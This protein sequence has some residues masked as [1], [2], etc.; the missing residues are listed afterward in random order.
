MKSVFIFG[1]GASRHAGGPLMSDFFDK[2]ERLLRHNKVSDA[3]TE[4]ENV[5]K[6]ISELQP[7]HAKSYFD[8]D[9]LEMVFGAIEMGQLIHKFA[10]RSPEEIAKLR[11]AMVTLIVKTL[12]QSILFPMLKGQVHAPKPYQQFSEMLAQVASKT[13]INDFSFI[14]FNYDVALDYALYYN[15]IPTDYYLAGAIAPNSPAVPLLKLHG[16]INWGYCPTCDEIVPYKV[17]TV[18]WNLF[19]EDMPSHVLFDLGSKITTQIHNRCSHQLSGPPIIV[20]PTWDKTT[21]HAKLDHVWRR[22]A[23]ELEGAENIFV[24]GYSLPDS[25]LFFRYLFSLGSEGET[26]IKRF[27]VLDPDRNAVEPRFKRLIGRGLENRFQ[28]H[29]LRFEDSIQTI[30]NALED[31]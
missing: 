12:E 28:F 21:H 15:Q 7:M 29:E 30:R 23:R 24:I 2:A 13:H 4:F 10:G 3:K 19:R 18:R 5:F 25:D 31:I 17:D 16:S 6:A 22:A 27:W 14:T 11:D 20:P 1:A 8:L 26:R 9:N